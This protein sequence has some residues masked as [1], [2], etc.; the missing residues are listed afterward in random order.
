[1]TDSP[2]PSGRPE[3]ARTALFVLF[4]PVVFTACAIGLTLGALVLLHRGSP[5][6]PPP[7]RVQVAETPVV[8]P[9]PD[10]A[11]AATDADFKRFSASDFRG[12]QP[13]QPPGQPGQPAP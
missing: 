4:R 3:S 8:L 10:P 9:D 11:P 1:M 6:P 13:G 2:L 12:F 7:D 5:P